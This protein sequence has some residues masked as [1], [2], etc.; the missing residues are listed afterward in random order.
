M[1]DVHAVDA[2]R[3]KRV[4]VMG[5]LLSTGKLVT[6]CLQESV[7]STWFYAYLTGIA[8][9]VKQTYNLPLVLIVNN[10]SIPR[11]NKIEDNISLLNT[12]PT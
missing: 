3:L 1:G 7:T 5:C 8:Q 2:I 4:N 11:S 6:S 10:A 9:Q 12:H